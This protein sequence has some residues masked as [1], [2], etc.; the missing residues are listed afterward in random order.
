MAEWVAELGVPTLRE[1]EVV[2]FAQD[3]DGVDV[4]LSDGTSRRAAYLVGCDGGRSVVRKAAGIDFPG[5]DAST[6]WMI[7]EVELDEEPELGFRR[8]ALGQHAMGRRAPDE[9]VRVVLTEAAV[10]HDGPPTLDDRRAA[11]RGIY[12]TDFGLRRAT[13]ISRF[14]DAVRQ[15]AGY[16]RDRVLLAGDAAHVHPPQGGQGLN[17]GVHDA[18]NLGWKLARVV[19]GRVPDDLLDTYHAERH[20]AAARVLQLVSAMVALSTPGERHDALRATLTEVLSFDEP[21]RH[22][23]STLAGLDVRYDLGSDHPLVGRHLPD[24]DLRDA[25]PVVLTRPEGTVLVRPD[26]HVAWVGDADDPGL[27]EACQRW[28]GVQSLSS[29]MTSR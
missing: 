5:I 9:P 24:L 19:D 4:E 2:G 23:A 20:P 13:W 6:S 21:R 10:E 18:V 25:Q 15:A 14:T 17:L 26:G 12:G 11:P 27:A 3:D 29:T 8:D 1:R 7:A 22:L 28:F 16:R